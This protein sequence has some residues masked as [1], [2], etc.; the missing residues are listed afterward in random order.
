[1]V[2][3]IALDRTDRNMIDN[4]YLLLDTARCGR[5]LIS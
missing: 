3:G 2:R 1:M 4:R 5:K